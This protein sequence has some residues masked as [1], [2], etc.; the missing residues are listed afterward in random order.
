MA[1]VKFQDYKGHKY[2]IKNG[3]L[4]GKG[5]N[6]GIS[7]EAIIRKYGSIGAYFDAEEERMRNIEFHTI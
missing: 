2:R 4:Y 7:C 3:Y 1:G 6:F 5:W